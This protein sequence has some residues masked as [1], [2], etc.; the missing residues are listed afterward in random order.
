MLTQHRLRSLL[1]YDPSTGAF[2]ATQ[3]QGSYLTGD[4]VGSRRRSGA[5]SISVDHKPYVAHDLVWLYVH[6]RFPFNPIEH[7]D[8]DL[9]ND[10]LSNLR[11]WSFREK[12]QHDES[13]ERLK[14]K[15]RRK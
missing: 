13:K 9:G 4:V 2:R 3:T 1:S 11:E 8:G 5:T 7:L 14:H 12:I 15:K 10:K 6:N